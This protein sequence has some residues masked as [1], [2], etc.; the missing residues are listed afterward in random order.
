MASKRQ[1]KEPA[2]RRDPGLLMRIAA[3]QFYTLLVVSGIVVLMTAWVM[4]DTRA[5]GNE[6]PAPLYAYLGVALAVAAACGV[7]YFLRRDDLETVWRRRRALKE[8]RLLLKE[9]RRGRTRYAHRLGETQA[10][11]LK[12]A[13][14]A[15]ESARDK[16]EW[17]RLPAALNEVD[18]KLDDHLSFA[19]KSTAREYAESIGVAVLI[20][21]FLRAFVV[22]AFRIPSGSMIPT[23]QVGDHIFVNKFI[24]GL[25]IPFT[26]YKIGMG[27]RK[28]E[29]GEII[30]FKFPREPEKD[31]IKRIIAVEGDTVEVRGGVPHINGK[32]IAHQHDDAR[33]C[34]YEDKLD[35]NLER[36]EHRQC[37]A[38][39]ET[40]DS[41]TFT[42]I[43]NYGG[44]GPGK[45]TAPVTVP[46]SHVFVM[47]DNRDNSHDSRYW[48]FVPY[49]LIKGKAMI[50][51]FSSGPPGESSNGI[52]RILQ[53]IR[54][55]RMF[56]FVR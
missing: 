9:V 23:L 8:A 24:Y 21:L 47:G 51:W 56:H 29:R 4:R 27:W 36:W 10:A 45:D 41:R 30:V 34:E 14:E 52:V 6:I 5:A 35:E 37:V 3:D 44:V 39:K 55:S 49:E 32:P 17:E 54:G 43:Y 19:R 22:E 40:L 20:A 11:E 18:K 31:F 12:A 33:P 48:G 2:P 53:G 38:Y 25:R 42:A 46:P 28:P 1:T 13:E 50:I 7:L 16:R 15:L 26:D